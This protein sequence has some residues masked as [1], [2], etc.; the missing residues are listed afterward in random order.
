MNDCQDDKIDGKFCFCNI[1]SHEYKGYIIFFKSINIKIS[2]TLDSYFQTKIEI[3]V[4]TIIKV[5][6]SKSLSPIKYFFSK[7]N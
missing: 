7:Q 1:I 5:V 6:I 3:W 2:L 4:L